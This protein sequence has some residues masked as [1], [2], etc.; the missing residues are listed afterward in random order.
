V[1][2]YDLRKRGKLLCDK[3]VVVQVHSPKI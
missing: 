1:H 2:T 3:R